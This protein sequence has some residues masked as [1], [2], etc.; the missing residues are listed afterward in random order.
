MCSS[1]CCHA[2]IAVAM[3]FWVCRDVIGYFS[4]YKLL[5]E[6]FLWKITSFFDWFVLKVDVLSYHLNLHRDQPV[7]SIIMQWSHMLFIMAELNL[8][9]NFYVDFMVD[10]EWD[11][12]FAVSKYFYGLWQTFLST[13]NCIC[14]ENVAVSW[15]CLR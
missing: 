13:V 7:S 11:Y 15:F 5:V 8:G 6:M 10:Y 9:K 1:C 3:Y 14:S 4:I 2:V 12:I